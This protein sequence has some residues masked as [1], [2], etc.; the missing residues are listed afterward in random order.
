MSLDA[1]IPADKLIAHRGF[2]LHYPENSPLAIEKAIEYG[3]IYV[4]VDVQFSADGIPILYHDD[5][6]QRISGLKGK[7]NQFTF[8]QLQI[9]TAGEPGRFGQTFSETRISPLT[10]LTEILQLHPAVQALV[11]LKEEAVRDYGADFCIARIRQALAPVTEQC[12]LISFDIQALKTAKLE[13]YQ[14]LA[15]VIRDWGLRQKIISELN[16]EMVI[17]N[18]KR[19]PARESIA[20]PDCRVALYEIDNIPLAASLLAR[21]A[22]LIETFAF[23]EMCGTR[24]E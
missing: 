16:A 6:L 22:D 20:M 11:E 10:A 24:H 14:R 5:H 18:Y 15:P 3:A 7:L 13:G 9:I 4:E 23:A 2:Q 17:C 1:G 8:Q 21:G 19:I 12:I